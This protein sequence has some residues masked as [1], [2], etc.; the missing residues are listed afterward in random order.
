MSK[1][2]K[3]YLICWAILL[4]AFN[5]ICFVTPGSIAGHS[6]FTASF[7]I[8]YAFITVS[9]IGQL[10]CA[11]IAFKAEN[12]RKLFHRIPI[13]AVSYTGLGS[14]FA[15]GALC[16]KLPFLPY[17]VGVVGCVIILASVAMAVGKAVIASDAVENI[18]KKIKEQTQFVRL[19]TVDA[20][21]IMNR[22]KS[23]AVRAEGRK[24]Y[25]AIRY[26]DPMSSDALS[27]EEAKITVKLNE[28]SAAV[29]END[30]EKTA[31]LSEE[32]VLLVSERNNKCKVLK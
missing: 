2:T 17:W 15:F 6:K 24:V 29:N 1:G 11:L 31:A 30:L 3:T 25:E 8:G 20:L 21:N 19:A 7:W 23:D 28:L 5:V 12:P 18:D 4:A 32:L 14:S 27:V 26:S 13:I 9:L 16:M 22:A 10:V